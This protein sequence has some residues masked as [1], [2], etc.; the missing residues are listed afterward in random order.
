MIKRFVTISADFVGFHRWQDAP[1]E[2]AFLRNLHRHIFKVKVTFAVEHNDRNIEF[3]HKK[4]RLLGELARIEIFLRG[5][6]GL[7]CEEIAET[8]MRKMKA[9]R[10]IVSEDGENEAELVETDLI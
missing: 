1:E 7:S 2:E 3:F 6:D 4:K 9:V 8:L 10:V 5:E